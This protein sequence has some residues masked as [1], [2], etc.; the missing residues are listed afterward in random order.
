MPTQKQLHRRIWRAKIVGFDTI[1]VENIV[2]LYSELPEYNHETDR[3][4]YANRE[5]IPYYIQKEVNRLF[6]KIYPRK[7]NFIKRT[8]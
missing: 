2:T 4:T 3:V 1:I 7:K 8:K 6:R 5:L